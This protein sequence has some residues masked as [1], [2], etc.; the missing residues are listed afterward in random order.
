MTYSFPYLLLLTFFAFAAVVYDHMEDETLRKR[1]NYAAL[2]VFFVFFAFRGYVYTDWQNYESL[3]SRV[4]W[5]FMFSLTDSES[6]EMVEPGFVALCMC[7]K[8]I[9]ESYPLLVCVCTL[10]NT[11]LFLRFL[12]Q[13]HIDNLPLAFMLFITFQGL[14]IMFNLLRNAISMFIFMNALQYIEKR[15]PLPYFALCTAA[16]MFHMSSAVFFPLYFF[17]NRRLN[18]WVYLGI[19]VALM[20]FFLSKISLVGTALQL[21]GI[22]GD[23][24]EAYTEN[25]TSSRGI[26]LT[27]TLENVS[28]LALVMLYYDE[29]IAKHRGHAVIVNSLLMYFFMYYILAEFKI[30]S[31]RF[32]MLFSYSFWILWADFI[33]LLYLKNNRI[34]L[35]S[36]IYLYCAFIL[37]RTI[38]TPAQEYDNLLFGAKSMQERQTILHRTYEEDD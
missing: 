17:L 22:E 5:N 9:H 25:L 29:I 3:L 8:T 14:T 24:V 35:S 28:L 23:K 31:D 30:M 15:K 36:V 37:V 27:D 33:H 34:L 19:A 2:A 32:A 6:K 12:R 38:N 11:A 4:E 21:A 13:R 20:L 1:I 18:R 16:L 7:C 10:I 26:S